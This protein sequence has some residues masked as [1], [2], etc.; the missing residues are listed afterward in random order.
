MAINKINQSVYEKK[1]WRYQ[2]RFGMSRNYVRHP[3]DRVQL[4]T[5]ETTEPPFPQAAALLV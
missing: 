1:S 3:K 2:D 5:L 4:Y